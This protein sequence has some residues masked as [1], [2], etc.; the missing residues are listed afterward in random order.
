[1]PHKL[2]KNVQH[3][4]INKGNYGKWHGREKTYITR[5]HLSGVALGVVPTKQE[6]VGL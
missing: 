6:R 5:N 4:H 3:M 1:M 2:K